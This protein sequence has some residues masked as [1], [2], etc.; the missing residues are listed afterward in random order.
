L[1]LTAIPDASWADDVPRMVTGLLAR[2]K[3][4]AWST[5]TANVWGE[6]ALRQFSRKF[7]STP[8]AGTT[9]TVLGAQSV[10][11]DWKHVKP[12]P[13]APSSA[14]D[15]AALDALTTTLSG[16]VQQDAT[17]PQ[18]IYLPWG[19]RREGDLRIT[20]HGTGKPWVTLQSLAAVPRKEAFNA[21]YAVRKT[22][23]PVQQ[24]AGGAGGKYQ[25]GDVLRVR[26]EVEAG[27]DMTWVALNDPI[28]AGAA[29]LGGG[30]GRDSEVATRGEKSAEG[31][32]PAFED[33]AQDAYR[34]YY[35]YLPKGKTAVEYTMRLN[36][37]GTFALPPTRAEAL[38]APEVFGEA[39]N[40]PM[41]VIQGP[42]K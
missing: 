28:P 36:N 33:R 16:G 40:A 15:G 31:V 37:A 5:T 22:I 21:G 14:Q 35:A 9:T 32:W 11:V 13:K 23:T 26:L 30:L 39:P 27:A 18:R 10:N 8:V 42:S 4:G 29:I 7:E 34:A 2:Q 20:H 3:G 38:Y 25:R 12:Q 24:A 17:M 41:T 19:E 1:L 6:L